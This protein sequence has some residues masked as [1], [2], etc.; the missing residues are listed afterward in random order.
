MMLG[1][2]LPEDFTWLM[3]LGKDI[4]V[5]PVSKSEV[6]S[7]KGNFKEAC[8]KL[9]ELLGIGAEGDLGFLYDQPVRLGPALY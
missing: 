1:C 6:G 7:F 4:P 2:V 3:E 5:L 8:G 9:R